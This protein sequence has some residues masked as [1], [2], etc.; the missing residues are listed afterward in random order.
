MKHKAEKTSLIQKIHTFIVL[1]LWRLNIAKKSRLFSKS[2]QLLRV[3]VIAIRG[4]INDKC[5]QKASALT[6]YSLLAIV[7]IAAMAFGF[8]KGFGFDKYL[9]TYIR[10][11]LEGKDEVINQI[12]EFSESMLAKTQ[13]GVIAGIGFLVLVWSIIKV[14]GNVEMSFNQIWTIT[15]QRSIVRKISDYMTIVIFTPILLII[16]T[17]ATNSVSTYVHNLAQNSEIISHM[18]GFIT[19]I[20]K[21]VPYS[22]IWLTFTFFY[23]I[24]PNTK[25]KFSSALLGGVIAGGI[26]QIVQY[27]YVQF[28]IGVSN[29]N[30]IYGSFAALPLFLIW[31]QMSWTIILLGAEIAYATQNLQYFEHEIESTNMSVSLREKL[32]IWT[33]HS[34]IHTFEKNQTPPTTNDLRISLDIPHRII[35]QIVTELV[36]AHLVYEV[37]TDNERVFGYTP[38][39]FI[40]SLTIETVLAHLRTTGFT[41]LPYINSATFDKISSLYTDFES[42]KHICIKDI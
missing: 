17:N 8:A 4:F 39:V 24:M 7:P 11:V 30:A 29:Y 15:K 6:Y 19:I 28:Q 1:D 10:S 16:S 21:L 25:V 36:D 13:G 40:Q 3:F 35:K 41:K 31:L 32:C 2:V 37:K 42:S 14:L 22:L 9:E 5:S 20:F 33:L 18:Y 27:F 23:F 38:A 26:F 34:I 12:L